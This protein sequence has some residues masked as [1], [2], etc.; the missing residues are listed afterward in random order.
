[1]QFKFS[2]NANRTEPRKWGKKYSCDDNGDTLN[3][4]YSDHG[5]FMMLHTISADG[6]ECVFDTITAAQLDCL[7][8]NVFEPSRRLNS[9]TL[10][11]Q[12]MG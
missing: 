12:L 9:G 10:N 6:D 3:A 8:P 2:L 1:M 5:T 4:Y 11:S 7:F